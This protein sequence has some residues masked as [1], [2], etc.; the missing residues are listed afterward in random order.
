MISFAQKIGYLQFNFGAALKN[1]KTADRLHDRILIQRDIQKM[2]FATEQASYR[3]KADKERDL[4]IIKLL[5]TTGLRV[6]ELTSLTWENLNERDNGGQLTV[7]G[8]G[9]K[10]RTVIIPSELWGE[11][12]NFKANASNNSPVF[13]SRKGGGHLDR[14]QINR[15]VDA[16]A[17]RA[18]INKKVSPHWL[19]HAHATHALENG[20]DIGL[21]QQTLGHAN[22][23]TTSRYLSAR[24]ERSSSQYIN[25]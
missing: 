22:V 9:D 4:L 6:S 8:N 1:G 16:I 15:I 20:A 2:I 13:A 12:M 21:V 3:Y 11:L 24:P 7:V 14:S 10:V 18:G 17:A 25:L 5:Y 23:A 19:R